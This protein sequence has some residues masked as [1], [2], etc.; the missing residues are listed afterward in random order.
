MVYTYNS[1][2]PWRH[3]VS[4]EN[5]LVPYSTLHCYHCLSHD[6]IRSAKCPPEKQAS[7]SLPVEL[8]HGHGLLNVSIN[9]DNKMKFS[10]GMFCSIMCIE[11]HDFTVKV[12]S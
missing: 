1:T 9:S 4:S 5:I 7:C 10:C 8:L 2:R 3:P 12:T 11:M 6:F